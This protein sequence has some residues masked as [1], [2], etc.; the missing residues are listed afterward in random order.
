LKE[1]WWILGQQNYGIN[2]AGYVIHSAIHKGRPEYRSVMHCHST[3]G[4][5]VA[6]MKQGLMNISQNAAITGEVAYHDYE[7]LSVNLEERDRLV[8]DLGSAKVMI[9]R[10]HGL[11]TCGTS[12]AEAFFNMYMVNRAC[13]MQIAALSSGMDNI[14]WPD[15]E[16]QKFTEQA[17][18]N[19]NPEGIG[20]KE[21]N[22]L[23]R[24]LDSKDLS[25]KF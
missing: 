19:F 1:I 14:L 20:Y 7:G 12:I 22:A 23:L 11:L 24:L 9:L 8:K 17:A 16:T 5:G 3:V 13:E 25:Y 18:A 4:V 15:I 2:K 6:C 21:F 10:N